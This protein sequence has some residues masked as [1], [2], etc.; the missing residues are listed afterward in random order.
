MTLTR[1][2]G[3]PNFPLG[4]K[5][6]IETPEAGADFVHLGTHRDVSGKRLPFLS[7]IFAG[8]RP[9]SWAFDQAHKSKKIAE[10]LTAG[11][12]R[13]L[14]GPAAEKILVHR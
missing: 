9:T 14:G 6:R 13:M 12:H 8:T 1:S 11:A 4:V 5:T 2:H 3:L 10:Y 7:R